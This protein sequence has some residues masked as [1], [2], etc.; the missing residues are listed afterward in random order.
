[1]CGILGCYSRDELGQEHLSLIERMNETLAHR[2]PNDSGI[3]STPNCILGHRRLSII[4]LSD[5]G[6]QP[7]IS[8]DGNL[9]ML[10]NG[11][12][13]NYIEL[14]AELESYGIR[15]KSQTDTEV[16]LRMYEK[17][18]IDAL[19]KLNGMFAFSIFNRKTKE[20]FIARDRAGVKPLYYTSLNGIFYF[21]SEIKALRKIPAI[22]LS[23]NNQTLFD[24]LC[25]NRTDI[26]EETFTSSIHRLPKGHHMTIDS[27]GVTIKKWWEPFDYVR[28]DL[29]ITS[30]EQVLQTIEEIF[31][32][33]VKLRMR[34]DVP[35]GSCLSGGLDS[36]IILGIIQQ[37]ALARGD[38]KTFTVSY[39]GS[40]V[41][42]THF[43]DDLKLKYDFENY[44][45]FPNAETAIDNFEKFT[46]FMDEPC[47]S[48]TFYSQYEVMRLARQHGTTVLLDG[49]GGDEIF[50]GYQY[51]HGFNFSE[52]WH[53]KRIGKLILE[54]FTAFARHQE[55]E[56]F[57]TFLFQ[58]L[59]SYIKKKLLYRSI[60]YIQPE[61]YNRHIERSI[62]F[63]EFFQAKSLNQSLANHFKYKLEHLLRAEDRNSMAF[64]IEARVPYLDYRLIEYS[65]SLPSK[66]KISHG[67][68][69]LLQKRS[70]GK[71]TI[72]NILNRKDKIGFGTPAQTWMKTPKWE[73]FTHESYKII[74]EKL[75]GVFMKDVEL[76]YNLFDRWKV[77]QIATWLRLNING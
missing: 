37:N 13:Y 41:D 7:Y 8:D 26:G 5:A 29:E 76:K 74:L 61:F 45:I 34:S 20:L 38:Y 53:K 3:Y 30:Q 72:D 21:A 68:N 70:L 28:D 56:A 22:D 50:A 49:Q 40:P 17:Y 31:V 11:E 55:K 33:A 66:L 69:K 23:L 62:I 73:E 6:H 67:E 10:F 1:M 57:F 9:I 58:E 44:R 60:G 48:P 51:F 75:P 43:I 27:R 32:S 52:L 65:L 77:N 46:Y 18:G 63:Q 4:D 16:L 47:S 39:P 15:F 64:S 24:Y 36:S 2:G 25:F 71:Y 19:H 14:R 59:P 35:V 54:L 12:I 42:E